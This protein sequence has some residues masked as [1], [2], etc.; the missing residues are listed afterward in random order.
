MDRRKLG[1]GSCSTGGPI[2][3]SIISNMSVP[4]LNQ[5]PYQITSVEFSP[6]GDQ[7]LASY[8]GEGVYLFDIKVNCFFSCDSWLF[9]K[10]NPKE[11]NFS[12][13]YLLD[14]KILIRI[15]KS[16]AVKNVCVQIVMDSPRFVYCKI[17]FLHILL[18]S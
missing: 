14:I 3:Q 12:G 9:F 15:L 1:K 10:R 17:D 11:S 18:D 2:S 16:C 5:R 6:E 8:S 7:L 4:G 13:L